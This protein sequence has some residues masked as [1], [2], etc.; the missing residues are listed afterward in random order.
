M[1]LTLY[2]GQNFLNIVKDVAYQDVPKSVLTDLATSNT[3]DTQAALDK[4]LGGDNNISIDPNEE[5]EPVQHSDYSAPPAFNISI[6][7]DFL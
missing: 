2:Q 6:I 3:K 4:Y 1:P 7:S 5:F